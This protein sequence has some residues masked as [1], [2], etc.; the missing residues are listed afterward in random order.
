[1]RRRGDADVKSRRE[2]L[3][4]FVL[5]DP[6]PLTNPLARVINVSVDNVRRAVFFFFFHTFLLL[7]I[8]SRA[9]Y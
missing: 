2:K 8:L 9:R 4:Y 5:R 6:R 3:R 1:M 7:R